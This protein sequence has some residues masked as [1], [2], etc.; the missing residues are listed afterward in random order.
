M[1]KLYISNSTCCSRLECFFK[2]CGCSRCHLP[3]SIVNRIEWHH[4]AKRYKYP[5]TRV[6]NSEHGLCY[7]RFRPPFVSIKAAGS[8]LIPN[9]KNRN[10]HVLAQS[11][12]T[13][14]RGLTPD[15]GRHPC[16]VQYRINCKLVPPGPVSH[17]ARKFQR[18]LPFARNQAT[19]SLC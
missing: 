17:G 15:D 10:E 13:I 11:N 4:K 6:Y 18:H 7:C 9:L 2:I 8:F 12:P 19:S 3:S 16:T 14:A 1:S 5:P